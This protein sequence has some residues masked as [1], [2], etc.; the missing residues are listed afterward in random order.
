[1]GVV[2]YPLM[3][4]IDKSGRPTRVYG[5]KS[6]DER[7]AE[8]R[9]LLLDAGIKV[10]GECGYRASTVKQ[11]CHEA[12]LTDRYF[13]LNFPDKEALLAA[14]YTDAMDTISARVAE[15]VMAADLTRDTSSAIDA[16]LTA[17]FTAIEDRAIAR[18]GWLEVLGVSEDIDR[19]YSARVNQFAD[20]LLS[21]A[22]VIEPDAPRDH[23]L[24]KIGV[25]ALVGAVSQTALHWLLDD[26][27]AAKS[28]LV[29]AN[30]LLILGALGASKQALYESKT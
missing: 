13:Y 14:V 28:D 15:S 25:L 17:F 6:A 3:G 29:T 7:Q 2:K 18:I 24:L 9:R 1:M 8:Q 27:R 23:P 21:Y 12:G 5:G 19:L 26:Y 4:K 16:G 10:F 22:H 20:L 30:R 11:L